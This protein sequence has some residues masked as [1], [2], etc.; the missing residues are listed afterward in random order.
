MK[1]RDYA[2]TISLE[3]VMQNTITVMLSSIVYIIIESR[4][5]VLLIMFATGVSVI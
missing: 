3:N 1:K 5:V 2:I 4:H